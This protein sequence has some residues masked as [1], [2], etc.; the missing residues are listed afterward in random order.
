MGELIWGMVGAALGLGL[1]KAGYRRGQQ[2][3]REAKT[4]PPMTAEQ[5]LVLHKAMRERYNFLNFE[6]DEMRSMG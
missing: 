4:A 1:F 6:G 5:E 2:A 3:Q